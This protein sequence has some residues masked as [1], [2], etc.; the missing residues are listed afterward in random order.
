MQIYTANEIQYIINKSFFLGVLA[1]KED[2]KTT[3]LPKAPHISKIIGHSY[4]NAPLRKSQ[5]TSKEDN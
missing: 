1:G 4:A 3:K 2:P 5:E